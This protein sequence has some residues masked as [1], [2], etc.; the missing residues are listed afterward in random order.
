MAI[1]VIHFKD[2]SGALQISTLCMP[3]PLTLSL[4]MART[5]CSCILMGKR[6]TEP[7]RVDTD[8]PALQIYITQD[9]EYIILRA[10]Q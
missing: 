1:K 10:T 5:A 7:Q 9:N 8:K 6:S 2:C 4:P 3:V